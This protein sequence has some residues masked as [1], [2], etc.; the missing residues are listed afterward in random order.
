MVVFL[1]RH[2]EA[3]PS[4]SI[5]RQGEGKDRRH[6]SACLCLEDV[7][8]IGIS[9]EKKRWGEERRERRWWCSA[10]AVDVIN[11]PAEQS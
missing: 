8:L 5:P 6:S 11:A 1:Q 9:F 7:S 10:K 2:L 4:A 3:F